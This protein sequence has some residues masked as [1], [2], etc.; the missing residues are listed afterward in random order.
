MSPTPLVLVPTLPAV[1]CP[2]SSHCNAEWPAN[3]RANETASGAF[4]KPGYTGFVS[5]R[6]EPIDKYAQWNDACEGS[7]TRTPCLGLSEPKRT[8][9]ELTQIDHTLAAVGIHSALYCPQANSISEVDGY[10]S[11]P[12]TQVGSSVVVVEATVCAESYKFNSSSPP[13]RECRPDGTWGPAT[14]PCIRT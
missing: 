13:S 2:A 5:R 4:C 11:W 8:D 7:C 12:A 9:R 3:T 14:N 1:S 10:A 6:C